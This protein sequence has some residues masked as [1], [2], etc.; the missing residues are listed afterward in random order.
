LNAKSKKK[1]P[2]RSE[3]KTESA[4]E[5]VSESIH[6][7]SELWQQF[8]VDESNDVLETSFGQGSGR[9]GMENSAKSSLSFKKGG[10]DSLSLSEKSLGDSLPQQSPSRNIPV[11]TP[12]VSNK[13]SAEDSLG[14]SLGNISV[15][16]RAPIPP[17]ATQS[18]RPDRNKGSDI[19]ESLRVQDFLAD[20]D[21]RADSGSLEHGGAMTMHGATQDDDEFSLKA[22]QDLNNIEEFSENS[23]YDHKQSM[24]EFMSEELMNQGLQQL[25]TSLSTH[26]VETPG[27]QRK[28][29]TKS[30]SSSSRSESSSGISKKDHSSIAGSSGS[31]GLQKHIIRGTATL[32]LLAAIGLPLYF[33]IWYDKD[34]DNRDTTAR[35][36]VPPLFPPVAPVAPITQAP[37]EPPNLVPVPSLPPESFPT[38]PSVPPITAPSV[39]TPTIP[40]AQTANPSGSTT[41]G[42]AEDL[43]NFLISQWPSLE[44]DLIG[45]NTPQFFAYDWLLNDPGLSEYSEQRILQRFTLATLYFSTDG[46]NWKRNDRWL[47]NENECLWYSA[48]GI[49]PCNEG[50]AYNILNLPLNGLVGTVPSELALLSNSLTHIDLSSR[51][52]GGALSGS[53]PNE[54][55][56]LSKLEVVDLSGNELQGSIAAGMGKWRNARAI[57]LSDNKLW[58]AFPSSFIHWTSL[59]TLDFSNN[60]LESSLPTSIGLLT[61]LRVLD[62]S[63]NSLTG[64]VPTEI[65]QLGMLHRL[66][67]QENRFTS[68]PSEIGSLLFVEQLF[69]QENEIAGSIPSDIG[70][71]VNLLALDLSNNALTSSIPPEIGNLVS[72]RDELNLSGNQ[73][74][75]LLPE[76]LGRLIFLRN[77]LLNANAL[78]G[79]IPASFANLDRLVTLRLE[80]N[81][82]MGVVPEPVCAVY[83]ETYPVFVTDCLDGE[84]ICD[85]CMFCCSESG[86]CECQFADTDLSFLCAEF[87]KSPGLE[88]RINGNVFWNRQ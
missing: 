54:L 10:N 30:D 71:L 53:I 88:D 74:T 65:G 51:E 11:A 37:S 59:Q 26:D 41:P 17:M 46:D 55:G 84:V 31:F 33:L 1:E 67:L 2:A 85:C 34:D 75:G 62:L 47:S 23:E 16:D 6:D 7:D 61:S 39:T 52:G 12:K 28:D 40:P 42:A 58:G 80:D 87:T 8:V 60:K 15:E 56:F 19:E 68:L 25:D 43:R 5:D 36:P 81:A 21:S 22:S 78:T 18:T 76:E 29:A 32:L 13:K 38:Q 4:E 44:D 64:I 82:L 72:I 86:G 70:K 63:G 35:E 45:L 24:Q 69:A 50:L 49:L 57:D 14:S 9:R 20:S 27:N 79:D 73:L 77:L 3:P 66:Y 83:S 48:S